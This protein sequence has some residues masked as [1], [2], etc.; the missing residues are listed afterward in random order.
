MLAA[1]QHYEE[2]P[3]IPN[4]RTA[5]N[6]T[7]QRRQHAAR[8]R[9]RGIVR[10]STGLALALVLVMGYMMLMANLTTLNYSVAKA[11]RERAALQGETLRLDD[12]LATL[13]SDDRLAAIAARL[14]MREPQQYA[15]VTLP[16]P[17]APMR[18]RSH[19]ALLSSFAVWLHAK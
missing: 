3:R 4:L 17:E 7:L 16:P 13:R 14:G 8:A 15:V 18:D 2:R 1:P 5:K 12:R 9:Y 19:V 10:F 11:Q 6:A